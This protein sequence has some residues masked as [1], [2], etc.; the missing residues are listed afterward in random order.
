MNTHKI[1]NFKISALKDSKYITPLKLEYHQNG[2]KKQWES[3]KSFDSVSVL[4]YH[5]EYH[6]FLLVKQFRPPVYLSNKEHGITFELCAGILDKEIDSLHTMAEE[7]DEESGYIVP[8]EKI[9]RVTSFYT[10]VGFSGAKQILYYA[11]IDESMKK[12]SGGGIGD[13]EIELLF[14]PV[15]EAKNF[16]FDESKPKTPGLMFAFYWFLMTRNF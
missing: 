1:E 13:E 14:L 11:E 4:L 9:E 12:H 5:V 6:A 8:L 15:D 3:V 7:I 10:G 2:I 16:V